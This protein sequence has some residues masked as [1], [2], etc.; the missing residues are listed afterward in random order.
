MK[1]MLTALLAAAVAGALF[2]ASP[3]GAMPKGTEEFNTSK[4]TVYECDGGTLT[5]NAPEKLWPPNHK[6]YEDVYVL[7]EADDENDEVS[8]TT[9]GTHDQYDADT[10][11][12]QNGSGNTADDITVDDEGAELTPESTDAQPVALEEGTGSVQTDWL[13]RSERSGRD[14][15]GRTYALDGTATFGDG[16]PCS[17]GVEMLVPHD[18]RP[19][20]R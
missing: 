10:G 1:K 4:A 9:T 20:N 11:A 15:T 8:L 14:K 17:G 13:V 2:V 7:A 19:S 5:L 6:Y 16:E 18:M 12:E 3:L